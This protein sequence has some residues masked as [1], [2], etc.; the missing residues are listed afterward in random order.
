METWRVKLLAGG[1]NLFEDKIQGG[2]FQ[3]DVLSPL[4][5]V[6]AMMPLN[7]TFR[8]CTGG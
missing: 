4:Q 8:K 1:K 3:G 6:I 2:T 7:H 5:F